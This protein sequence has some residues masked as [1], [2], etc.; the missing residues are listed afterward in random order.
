MGALVT[1]PLSRKTQQVAG[2]DVGTLWLMRRSGHHARCALIA[3]SEDWE[4][5]VL[6]GG[7]ILLAQRCRRGAAT[8]DLAEVWRRRMLDDGWNQVIPH[9]ARRSAR[10]RRSGT[11]TAPFR[12]R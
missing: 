9:S 2:E 11:R 3:L 6:V 12:V 8:F 4:L 5:R 7:E 1:T 10:E